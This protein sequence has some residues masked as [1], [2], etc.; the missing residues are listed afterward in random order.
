MLTPK[1][2]AKP[3]IRQ[4]QA[5]AGAFSKGTSGNPTGRPKKTEA[6][7]TLEQMCKA[8]TPEA[9]QT[10]LE[11]MAEGE[12]HKVKLSAAQY[13]IDRGWGKA[14][15]SVTLEGGKT[16]LQFLEVTLVRSKTT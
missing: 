5:N 12:S 2:G 3:A 1:Q 9:L 8:K 10:I 7:A 4:K 15:Q 11:I 14:A 6:E 16:P 13:V